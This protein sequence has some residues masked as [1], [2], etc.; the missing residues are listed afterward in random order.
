MKTCLTFHG[1]GIPG[2]GI[3]DAEGP[4]WLGVE[5]FERV[6]DALVERRLDR[7][8]LTFD[9]GNASDVDV[10]L[11]AL[12]ARGLKATFFVI[13]E[14]I[15]KAGYLSPGDI[16]LLT[17]AG[18]TVGTHG[19]RHIRWTDMADSVLDDELRRS[20]R[21]LKEITGSVPERASVPFGAYD[22]RVLAALR[23]H[24]LKRVY[25]SDPG[26]P[27]PGAWLVA[28]RTVRG[29][30]AVDDIVS[31]AASTSLPQVARTAWRQWRRARG[32]NPPQAAD[33]LKAA[34]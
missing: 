14:R 21:Q 13:T 25:T 15:G 11:P 18:M 19:A 31:M 29:D 3:A 32:F 34:P 17:G 33:L 5:K 20:R 28:R 22:G 16:R 1:L 6:L 23:R 8:E 2:A 24:G 30:M 9:D 27:V 7:A 4:Y 10:A 12:T 26:P